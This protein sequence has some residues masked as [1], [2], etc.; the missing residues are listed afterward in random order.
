MPLKIKTTPKLFYKRWIYKVVVTCGGIN[1]LHRNGLEY[2]R[3]IVPTGGLRW[4]GLPHYS[5][6]VHKNK[7][8][9]IIIGLF[10]ET[11]LTDK[12]YQIRAE[13]NTL[14]IFTN[15][16]QLVDTIVN[17]LT[18]F[19]TELYQPTDDDHAKFLSSNKSKV[20]C[21]EL[22]HETYRFK[23]YFKSGNAPSEEV[24]ERFLQWSNKFNDGRIHIPRGTERILNG[25]TFPYF[26][27]QYFYAKDEKM[28]A[29]A[30]MFMGDYLNKT[31]EYVLK[32]E[33]I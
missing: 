28:A 31:E 11:A 32:T 13:S 8:N 33:V 7:D 6:T 5:D 30:L 20:I 25:D 26:Y 2:V 15:D 14:A 17:N 27:G 21:N 3:D 24:R 23:I 10:L 18:Q 22:P 19:V 16:K 1:H 9:L 4:N 12:E 29:M